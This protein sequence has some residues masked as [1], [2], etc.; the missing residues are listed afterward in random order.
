MCY[1]WF[2]KVIYCLECVG[3][4]FSSDFL[5]RLHL[6]E[7]SLYYIQRH[8][9]PLNIGS[10]DRRLVQGCYMSVGYN[11][12]GCDVNTEKFNGLTKRKL[13]LHSQHCS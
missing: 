3:T 12:N 11:E 10:S 13:K 1:S 6:T 5:A 4:M 7:H 2:L 8:L 9:R